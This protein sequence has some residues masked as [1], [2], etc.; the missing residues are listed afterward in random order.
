MKSLIMLCLI[1]LNIPLSF[2]KMCDDNFIRR[3]RENIKRLKKEQV[4]LER[5]YMGFMRRSTD[6]NQLYDQRKNE[7]YDIKKYGGRHNQTFKKGHNQK[8]QKVNI[9]TKLKQNRMK[10]F[11]NVL[12]IKAC[13]K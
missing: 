1:I 2:G 3:K 8:L 12:S 7:K 13:G 9:K 5:E 4:R 10:I 6:R 11:N